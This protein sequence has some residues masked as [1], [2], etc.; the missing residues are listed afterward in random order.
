MATKDGEWTEATSDTTEEWGNEVESEVMIQLETE[1]EG[2]TG[3]FLEMEPPNRNGITQAHFSNVTTLT[4]E[5][6]GDAFINVGRDLERKLTKVPDKAQ[7]RIQWVSS[8]DTGQKTPM[9]VYKVQW[10]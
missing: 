8:M 3:R 10:R 4:G 2:F 7:V 1:G 5:V 9:R 6:I